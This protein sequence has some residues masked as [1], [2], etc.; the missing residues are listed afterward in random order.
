MEGGESY[1]PQTE[2][3][4]SELKGK[5]ADFAERYDPRVKTVSNESSN[6]IVEAEL[7]VEGVSQVTV[8]YLREFDNLEIIG[9]PGIKEK[10]RSNIINS[11]LYHRN[12]YIRLAQELG[13][14]VD[15]LKLQ[16]QRKVE[17]IVDRS[18]YFIAI[19]IESLNKLLNESGRFKTQFEVHES[20]A[21]LDLRARAN[22]EILMFGYNES[23]NFHPDTTDRS[24]D[25]LPDTIVDDNPLMRPVYGYFSADKHGAINEEGKIP[26]KSCFNHYGEVII[27]LKKR[28]ILKKTTVNFDDTLYAKDRVPS[29]SAQKPH[30]TSIDV[31]KLDARKFK[32]LTTS[33]KVNWGGLGT[34][35][36]FHGQLS[37]ESIDSVNI[38][39]KN[40]MNEEEIKRVREVFSEFMK[41]NRGS[42]IKLLY[43]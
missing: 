28:D 19:K 6:S 22:A 14:S 17:K 27:K 30:F 42:K 31:S 26:P 21:L 23:D 36:E 7:R 25:S 16:L 41:N 2:S 40:D 33:S 12:H 29:T 3:F 32:D 11:E 37:I 4:V 10:I 18:D 9:N 34:E 39:S 13:I 43:Y 15:E 20:G 38:S 35:A 5:F 24:G 1:F 8:E